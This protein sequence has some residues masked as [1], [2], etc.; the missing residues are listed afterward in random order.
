MP[1]LAGLALVVVA[2]WL[3]PRPWVQVR[4]LA[5]LSTSQESR[6]GPADR[7]RQAWAA[8][9]GRVGLGPASRRR[10]AHER[11]RAVQALGALA[12]ELEAGQSPREALLRAGGEPCVWP[13][14]SGAVRMDGDVPGALL[15]DAQRHP[16]LSHLAACWEVAAASGAGLAAAVV[17][18]ATAERAA[19]DVRVDL[20]GQLAGPRATARLLSLLPLVGI[21]VGMLLG[22]DP[23]AW[24][25]TTGPGRACLLAGLA[26]TALG[27]WWTGRIAARVERLL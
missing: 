15:V 22:S 5:L 17:R 19:E 27:T 7:A 20:E 21:G 10:A 13:V 16:P 14:A 23:L 11:S 2:A 4:M 24:L 8:L 25:L 26:L 9:V 6:A 12:A 1:A 18:L 3:S